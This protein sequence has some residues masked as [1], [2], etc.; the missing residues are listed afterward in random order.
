VT[1]T[2]RTRLKTKN[3]ITYFQEQLSNESWD[4]VYLDDI[5]GILMLCYEYHSENI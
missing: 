1:Y 5:S 3:K 4:S 2:H